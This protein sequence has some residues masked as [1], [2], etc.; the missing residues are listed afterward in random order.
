MRCCGFINEGAVPSFTEVA[1]Q[2]FFSIEVPVSSMVLRLCR[3]ERL[4]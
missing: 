3:S 4:M 2:V 1:I